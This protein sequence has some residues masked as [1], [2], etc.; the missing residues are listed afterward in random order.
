MKKDPISK[1]EA[2]KSKLTN[3]LKK[4]LLQP[5]PQNRVND[6]MDMVSG[7]G[8]AFGDGYGFPSNPRMQ[9]YE[10]ESSTNYASITLDRV[11]LTNAY[12]SQGLLAKAVD[13]PVDDS[14]AAKVTLKSA[15]LEQEEINRIVYELY[16]P[17]LNMKSGYNAA[18]PEMV[19]YIRNP[20]PYDAG[21]SHMENIKFAR[22]MT[23]VY[24]GGGL[25]VNTDQDFRT[26]LDVTA[27]RKDSPLE[28]IPCDRWEMALISSNMYGNE[29]GI[30]PF[31]YYG[32]P[33]DRSRVIKLNGKEAPSLVRPRLQGWG[34]SFIEGPLP[35][36]NAFM[37]FENMFF[38][39]LRE[40]KIDVY[41]IAGFNNL[42]GTATGTQQAQT[43]IGLAN[44]MKSYSNAIAMDS[45]DDYLQKTLNFAG[46]ADIW[47]ELRRNLSAYLGIPM[48]KL[49]G[50]SASGMGSG[51][52]SM[53]NYNATLR[54]ERT[55]LEPMILMAASLICQSLFGYVPEDLCVEFPALRELNGVEEEVV[56]TSIQDRAV[57][58][59]QMGL[60]S[61][62]ETM[63]YLKEYGVIDMESEV[64]NGDREAEA[65]MQKEGEIKS[66]GMKLK[67]KDKGDAREKKR[68]KAPDNREAR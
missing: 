15:E 64:L 45:E 54:V 33:V 42:L 56:L 12:V 40:A 49:F 30:S 17:R 20:K 22:K 11:L 7:L 28:F 47:N 3:K 1:L 39:L 58:L 25:I 9:P 55:Q 36:V 5:I 26:E 52:D 8:S 18:T 23:R 61:G 41:K 38:E 19:R 27:I 31:T 63:E 59:F 53:E 34:L 10:L 24:G 66:E 6:L 48:S 57:E 21:P 43:R 14:L 68:A 4:K 46:M 2:Q 32:I 35:A 37:R 50:E 67:A 65:P 60:L 44:M 29:D 13:L 16:R 51:E 62:K